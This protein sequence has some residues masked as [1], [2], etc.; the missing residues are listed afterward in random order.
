MTNGIRC[1]V[2]SGQQ[3]RNFEELRNLWTSAER[4]G[5]DWLSLFDHLRPPISGPDGP[6]LEGL[7]ALAALGAVTS[8]VRCA[9]MVAAWSWRDPA[10]VAAAASTIDHITG[11]R[12]ELGVG[13]GG[14]DLAFRQYGFEQPPFDARVRRLA[15][16]CLVLRG[17]FE[18]GPVSMS[19]E[20][21]RLSDAYLEP[22]PVQARLPLVV[23]G[24]GRP[25][26][27]VAAGHADTWN[28]AASSV[29]AWARLSRALDEECAAIGRDPQSVR[30]SLT[31][32]LM[33]SDSSAELERRRASLFDTQGP[34][35]PDLNEYICFGSAGECTEALLAFRRA[36]VDDFLLGLRP[37]LDEETLERFATEIA[38][39]LRD[40][41]AA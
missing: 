38:P 11:G 31:F 19:G 24:A 25:V 37:P 21:Y 14:H 36:G 12:F 35:P 15:E 5:Y 3:Y 39:V 33:I 26:L 32:R 40:E 27:R 28:T 23:G 34:T 20:F 7:T 10:V 9:I 22:P 17:L 8:R 16:A 4:L 18:G 29:N 30:R 6:C 2:H 41:N 1:G 13:A